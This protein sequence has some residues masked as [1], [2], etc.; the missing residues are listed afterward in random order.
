MQHIRV[1]LSS[2]MK[3]SFCHPSK[4]LSEA[5]FSPENKPFAK[6][7][8]QIYILG[9][10]KLSALLFFSLITFSTFAQVNPY[11]PPPPPPP[12]GM[13]V[14]DA[15]GERYFHFGLNVTP[16][17]YWVSPTTNNNTSNGASAGFGYGVNLEFYFTRNYGFLFGFEIADMGAKYINSNSSNTLD[18]TVT[19]NESLQY[20]EIPLMLKMKTNPFGKIRYYGVVGL[21]AGFLLKATDDFTSTA[22]RNPNSIYV[23]GPLEFNYSGN[24]ADIYSKTDFFR[25]SLVFGIGA[26][27][28]LAGS[29]ALQACITYNNCFTN[30]NS[31]SSNAVN[32]KG[33]E[34]MFGLLF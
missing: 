29:T 14:R 7:A 2:E 17:I 1:S 33:I 26:E 23:G 32:V 27:Y 18:T 31:S 8:L 30:M 13:N 25:L 20:L 19:H 34:L 22:I 28:T 16:G 3:K 12:T 24:N 10:M 15:W 11:A 4:P 21:Q 9:T 5:V 6:F